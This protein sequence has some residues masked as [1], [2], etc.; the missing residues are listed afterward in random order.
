MAPERWKQVEQLY[1]RLLDCPPAQRAALIA[2]SCSGDP[3]LRLELESLLDTREELGSFLSRAELVPHL[4]TLHAEQAQPTTNTLIGPYRILSLLGE[5]GMGEVYRARD[6]RLERE[7]ALKILPAHFTYDSGRVARFQREAKTASAL[8]HPNIITIY[9]IGRAGA[10]WFIAAELIEGITLRQRIAAGKI[11]WE[12]SIGICLQCAEA[13]ASAHR[14]GI[15]HRDIKPENLMLRPDGAVKVVDFGLARIGAP[16]PEEGLNL[17]QTGGIM[18]TPRYMSPEQA[19]GEDLDGR[20]DIFSLGAVLYE[21]G[22]GLPAFPGGT[23]AEVFAALLDKQPAPAE[24]GLDAVLAKALEKDRD[25]RYRSIEDFAGDLRRVD[26]G[27]VLSPSRTR[28]RKPAGARFALASAIL[29]LLMGIGFAWRLWSG[30][31]TPDASIDLVPLTSFSGPKDYAAFSP[32][33]DRIAFSWNGGREGVREHHIYIKP[34]DSGDPVQVTFAPEDDT[35]P[36]WSPDGRNIA[37]VRRM[38]GPEFVAYIVPASGGAERRI[39][40]GGQSVSWSPDGKWLALATRP[41]PQ[42]SNGIYLLS[43]E[44]GARRELTASPRNGRDEFAAWSPDGR[45]IAFM[46]Y[47]GNLEVCLVPAA[48]GAMRQLTS[49]SRQKLGVVTWMP[50]SLELLYSTRREYGGEGLWRVP[51]NGGKQRPIS[52]ALQFAGNPNVSRKGDRV[53]YTQSWIDT[54]IY[55][56]TSSASL[57]RGVPGQFGPPKKIIASSREDHSPGF[58]PDGERIVFVSNRTGHSEIW[59]ARRDGSQAEQLTRFASFAGTPRWS[60]DGKWIAFD[61]FKGNFDIWVIP[62]AGGDARQLTSDPSQHMLPSWSPDGRWIYF[63]SNRGGT[64]EIWKMTPDGGRL[65]QLTRRGGR[66]PLPSADAL[67]VYYTKS[68]TLQGAPVWCVPVNGGEEKP[69][70]GMTAYN[71]IGRAWGATANGIYFASDM[72][73]APRQPIRFFRFADRSVSTLDAWLE[74][75]QWAVPNVSMSADGRYLLTVQTDQ[76][77]ND[78]MMIRNFR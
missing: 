55:L 12:E 40:S 27:H 52:G 47:Q 5:G 71:Q 69:V 15:V 76:Q 57:P 25:K 19:R 8:N 45:W 58:S 68:Q 72:A 23:T 10:T 11:P 60:P 50:D 67:T 28:W 66:E 9:D 51:I 30:R 42:G 70:T 61:L 35:L 73:G 64:D 17:T 20:S 54:N 48:G 16:G 6:T 34:V 36:A 38:P 62:A 26:P 2:E 33:G 24:C 18:G 4:S 63:N 14:V 59:T 37:F 3:D 31:S 44:T 41:V 74:R 78:L 29:L 75:P 7:V 22:T 46:R 32:D 43:L 53:A 21:M 56:A 65:T 13:L 49:D 1:Y 39:A 77:S